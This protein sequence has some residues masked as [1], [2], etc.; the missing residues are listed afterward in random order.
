MDRRDRNRYDRNDYGLDYDRYE[1]YRN[2]EHYHSA[3]NLTDKFERDYQR[4]RGYT[5][6]DR[7]RIPHTYHEGNMGNAY[8]QYRR[9]EGGFR[10]HN[11]DNWNSRNSNQNYGGNYS[12]NRDRY[13][14][15]R[16]NRSNDE[17]RMW[18]DRAISREQRGNMGYDVSD[19]N[20]SY[21]RYDDRS[22]GDNQ[23][24]YAGSGGDDRRSRYGT[25]A[26]GKGIYNRNED[27]WYSSGHRRDELNRYY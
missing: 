27:N 13:D 24:Y 12:G 4:E 6:D 9:D 21:N 22:T 5:P 7:D 11:K 17:D 26:Y 15:Y 1:G 25:G 10:D 18:R 20:S 2:D 16:A 8:E 23:D 19:R 3:R 14:S